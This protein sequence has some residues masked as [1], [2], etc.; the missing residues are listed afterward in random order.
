[1]TRRWD[2][3]LTSFPTCI[4]NHNRKIHRNHQLWSFQV[5]PMGL[6]TAQRCHQ[7]RTFLSWVVHRKTRSL[8]KAPTCLE[9]HNRSL[10]LWT[11]FDL[12]E[13]LR[14]WQEV[15][16]Q[17]ALWKVDKRCLLAWCNQ[18]AVQQGRGKMGLS[19]GLIMFTLIRVM[20]MKL[21]N[22][23]QDAVTLEFH[24]NLT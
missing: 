21:F 3:F 23:I 1:M 5:P 10:H 11:P 8:L 6:T 9:T 18:R 4:S 16:L 17:V 7:D 19:S 12:E 14:G 2:S 13:K 15:S 24:V 22:N 20:L